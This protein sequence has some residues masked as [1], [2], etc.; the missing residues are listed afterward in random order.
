MPSGE[1]VDDAELDDQDD[2]RT[3]DV[4]TRAMEIPQILFGKFVQFPP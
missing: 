1:V 2:S 4:E 3:F